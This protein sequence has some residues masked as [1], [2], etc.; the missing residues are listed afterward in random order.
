[1]HAMPS[2]NGGVRSQIRHMQ[3]GFNAPSPAEPLLRK[4]RI[5]ATLSTTRR[6]SSLTV[7]AKGTK[8]RRAPGSSTGRRAADRPTRSTSNASCQ[9]RCR[10]RGGGQDA[11]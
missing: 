10:T 3:S 2:M 8:E 7:G 6:S 11:S 4:D 9:V 1:M 5:L